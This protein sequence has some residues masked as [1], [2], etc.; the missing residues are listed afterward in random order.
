MYPICKAEHDLSFV[1]LLLEN[2]ANTQ[3]SGMKTLYGMIRSW[4]PIILGAG[5]SI[6]FLH[7]TWDKVHRRGEPQ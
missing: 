7:G 6:A 2:C 4:Y 3:C 1:P 5:Y